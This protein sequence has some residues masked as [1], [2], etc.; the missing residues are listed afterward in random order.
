MSGNTIILLVEAI[1]RGSGATLAAPLLAV[2]VSLA[3]FLVFGIIAGQLA[4][5]RLAG[6]PRCKGWMA[7]STWV[8]CL[9]LLIAAVLVQT[10]V[11]QTDRQHHGDGAIVIFLLAASSGT[12]VAMA[13]SCGVSEIPTAMLTSPYMD[14]LTD[15]N[16]LTRSLR[17]ADVTSRNIRLGYLVFFS[18]GTVLGAVAWTYSG[19]GAVLWASFG[20]RCGNLA[21]IL[22]AP[23]KCSPRPDIEGQMH[24]IDVK[25]SQ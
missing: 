1:S 16:L 21:Y 4:L 15:A 10:D 3:S 23:V 24:R 20:L 12:Q 8:Q 22:L 2:G 11:L 6:S 18:S 9:L 17:S 25:S 13:K 14:L 5:T 7:F 19:T